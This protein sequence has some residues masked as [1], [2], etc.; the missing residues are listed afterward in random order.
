MT[1]TNAYEARQVTE[2]SE[3][4]KLKITLEVI[5]IWASQGKY[6]GTPADPISEKLANNLRARGFS[7]NPETNYISW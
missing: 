7:V 1:I 3:D 2:K 5:E 6:E 4:P